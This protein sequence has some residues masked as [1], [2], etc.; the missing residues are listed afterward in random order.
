MS[1]LAGRY[2]VL[3]D[4]QM[5]D[6]PFLNDEEALALSMQLI[7]DYSDRCPG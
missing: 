6:C 1:F 2:G 7:D 3:R 5:N 4:H